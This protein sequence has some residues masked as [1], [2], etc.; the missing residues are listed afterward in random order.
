MAHYGALYSLVR[1]FKEPYVTCIHCCW[2]GLSIFGCWGVAAQLEVTCLYIYIYIH[3]YIYTGILDL[4]EPLST[5]LLGKKSSLFAITVIVDKDY[6]AK[7]YVLPLHF[8]ATATLRITFLHNSSENTRNP[9]LGPAAA[10]LEVTC[11]YIC[12]C[13]YSSVHLMVYINSAR[14]QT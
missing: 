10:Q 14:A 13:I 4:W 6:I 1:P 11:L 9:I 8:F 5:E 12:I 3:M 7:A 2:G